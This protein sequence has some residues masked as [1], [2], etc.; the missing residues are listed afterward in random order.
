MTVQG[1]NGALAESHQSNDL[2]SCPAPCLK[3]SEIAGDGR[4]VQLHVR[5]LSAEFVM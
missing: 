4:S 3:N 1:P 2:K 5:I